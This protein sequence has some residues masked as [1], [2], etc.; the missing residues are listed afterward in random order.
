MK[1][2]LFINGSASE[3]SSNEKL[4]G[5][6]AAHFAASFSISIFD[7]LKTLPHFD[8]A[9]AVNGTPQAVIEF[10]SAI[11]HTDAVIICT[12]EYI[13]SIPGGLKNALEWCVSTTIFSEKPVGIIT[14]S[15]SGVKGHEELQLIMQTLSANITEEN[16][17]LI[18]GIKGKV[19]KKG[20]IKDAKT[21]AD[22]ASFLETF[23]SVVSR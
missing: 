2:I 23:T 3:N 22:L 20:A 18:Q 11:I 12:P 21:K 15:A 1:K 5:Y 17:I 7:R 8:P 10:R 6:L 4:I 14:A 13:F 9:H 19:D 16:C